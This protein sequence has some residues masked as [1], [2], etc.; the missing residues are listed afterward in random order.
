MNPS[1]EPP[2]RKVGGLLIVF[3]LLLAFLTPEEAQRCIKVVKEF[4]APYVDRY[5]SLVTALGIYTYLQWVVALISV[6]C[7]YV[8]AFKKPSAVTVAKRG[9]VMMVVLIFIA[10]LSIT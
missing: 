6:Y 10:N 2:N 1:L 7:A 3:I 5:Q 4:F 8:L 9:I